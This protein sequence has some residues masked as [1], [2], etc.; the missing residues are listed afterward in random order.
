MN[1]L[2]PADTARVFFAI[3]PESQERRALASWQDALQTRFGGRL[4]RPE[5][6]HVTLVFLG[7][8]ARDRLEALK[9]AAEE[10][11]PAR[12]DLCFDEVRYWGHNHILYAAPG[13]VPP[14]L[15]DWVQDLR[16]R[17]HL[18]HFAFE[19]QEYQPH[20]TLLRNV[21]ANDD[22]LPKMSPVTWQVNGF[23]LVQSQPDGYQTLAHFLNKNKI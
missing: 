18:H 2:N 3:W 13:V 9:L 17:L 23:V 14:E 11:S 4:M 6:L 5:T 1:N 8:V 20:V 22:P 19:L 12:F 10:V 16:Q 21:H 7:S 15:Q